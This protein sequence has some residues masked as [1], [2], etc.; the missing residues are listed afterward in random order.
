MNMREE[1]TFSRNADGIMIPSGE[2]VLIP[3]GSHAT[4]TQSLGGSFTLIT[5]R[6]LMV[7]VS[8][9]EV[10]A[11]GKTPQNVPEATQGE[12]VTPEK[13][14]QLV[15]DQLKTCYDPEIPVNIVDLGLVYLCELQPA[16]GGGKNVKIKMTLTAP[17]CGMGPVLA[18][19][20]RQKI[21]SLPGVKSA[22]I[23]VVFDPVWDRSMMSDA[24]K[25]Q[26]GMMW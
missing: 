2:R 20:V 3:N 19:D 9:K 12:E 10:E 15:W 24:A 18:H 26:L 14:E 4:I 5:D 1:V 22:D 23:E 8:G 21:E 13:L 17:G 25:L 16:E 6:G 7:R 11:I